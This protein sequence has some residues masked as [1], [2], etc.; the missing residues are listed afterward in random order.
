MLP[1]VRDRVRIS[2]RIPESLDAALELERLRRKGSGL[3][4]GASLPE[5]VTVAFGNLAGYDDPVLFRAYRRALPAIQA[6]PTVHLQPRVSHD[7]ATF[8][9]FVPALLRRRFHE[10]GA[11]RRGVVITA[12][13]ELLELPGG[14]GNP[15]RPE[16]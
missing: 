16:L 5:L 13:C 11:T 8:L 9:D 4:G 10:R 3:R 14:E 7:V 15:L 1:P 6:R 2:A 12:L